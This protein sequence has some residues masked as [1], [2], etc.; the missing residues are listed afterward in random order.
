M[1]LV[2]PSGFSQ[3]LYRREYIPEEGAGT[4]QAG[5]RNLNSRELEGGVWTSDTCLG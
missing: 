3:A 5:G 1:G 2:R 4:V